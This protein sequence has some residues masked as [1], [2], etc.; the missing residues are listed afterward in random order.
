MYEKPTAN[1]NTFYLRSG[2]MS[3]YLLS[4]LLFNIVLN[5][6]SSIIRQEKQ[7]QGIHIIKEV[8]LV[9]PNGTATLENSMAV[10]S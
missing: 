6:L 9:G 4:P 8:K 1:V 5:V 10:S 2:T 7:I 3:G